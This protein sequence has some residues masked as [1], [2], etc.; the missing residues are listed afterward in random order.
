[1]SILLTQ[2]G[3]MKTETILVRPLNVVIEFIIGRCQEENHEVIGLG[4]DTDLWFHANQMSSCH[5]VALIHKCP[6]LGKK[7]MKYVVK[8]GA[9]LC[10]QYTKKAANEKKFEVVYTEIRY[11]EKTVVPGQVILHKEKIVNV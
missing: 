3:Q 1:M 10:K 2:N 11:V 8:Q 5:V 9:I 4:A 6:S 7:D